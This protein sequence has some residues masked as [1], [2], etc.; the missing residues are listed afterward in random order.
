M[1]GIRFLNSYVK[2]AICVAGMACMGY[3]LYPAV[4][5]GESA[6][7]LM[8]IRGLVFLGFTYLLIRSVQEIIGGAARIGKD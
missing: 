8:V 5:Y 6:D 1:A 7:G 4:W 2:I 3:F